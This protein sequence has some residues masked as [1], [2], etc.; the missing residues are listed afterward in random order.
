MT[1]PEPGGDDK[2]FLTRTTQAE[3]QKPWITG[4]TDQGGA[5]LL[6]DLTLDPVPD[7][8]DPQSV[9][10]AWSWHDL[11]RLQRCRTGWLCLLA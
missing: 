2:V 1:D 6:Q 5:R 10:S 3:G 8:D 7:S 9:E 11:R 4:T